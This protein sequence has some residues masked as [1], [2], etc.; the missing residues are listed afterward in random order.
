MKISSCFFSHTTKAHMI[1]I[2]HKNESMCLSVFCTPFPSVLKHAVTYLI[3]STFSATSMHIDERKRSHHESRP[4][5]EYKNHD[6]MCCDKGE[7]QKAAFKKRRCSGGGFSQMSSINAE[8]KKIQVTEPFYL[9]M[10]HG[11]NA[12]Q[13]I[14][15]SATGV[16]CV[17][18]LLLTSWVLLL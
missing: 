11:R 14:F 16:T 8:K 7:E 13:C 2:N 5:I 3:S 17:K 18:R 1:S 12:I 15:S 10:N 4:C 9:Q 6:L